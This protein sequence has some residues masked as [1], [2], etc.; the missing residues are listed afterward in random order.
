MKK[1]NIYSMNLDLIFQKL[2]KLLEL[3]IKNFK[4]HL[5]FVGDKSMGNIKMLQ[6]YLRKEIGLN[7][8]NQN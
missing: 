3:K 6:I 2:T 5:K 8:Q 7:S 1:L 4:N